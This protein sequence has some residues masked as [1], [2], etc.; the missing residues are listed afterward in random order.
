M[1]ITFCS[2]NPIHKLLIA[3]FALIVVIERERHTFKEHHTDKQKFIEPVPPSHITIVV[4]C[5]GDEHPI[6]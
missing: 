4:D 3:I 5:C 6:M 1:L 2:V